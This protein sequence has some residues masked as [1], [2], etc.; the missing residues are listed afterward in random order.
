LSASPSDRAPT[1]PTAFTL[2][3]VLVVIAI[4]ALL[5]AIV[6][7]ALAAAR[8]SGD[9]VH[10][11]ASH[12]SIAQ[13]QHQWATDH[14]DAWPNAAHPTDP[15]S[16]L[17]RFDLG[18]TG[19]QLRAIDQVHTWMA[20]LVPQ[21][22]DESSGFE[23]WSCRSRLRQHG[24][25]ITQNP[26]GAAM[27]S[28]YQPAAMFTDPSLWTA[29]AADARANP[30]T[31]IRPVRLHEFAFASQKVSL[32]ELFAMHGNL[33]SAAHTPD[34][35]N[36]AFVDG[37]ARI[38]RPADAEKCLTYSGQPQ[39]MQHFRI[40]FGGRPLAFNSVVNGARGFDFR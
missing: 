29:D 37:H 36:A 25:Q 35:L 34:L 10:C 7:P 30:H 16:R 6:L 22:W 12:R 24:G 39:S 31:R 19:Y 5:L 26:A 32:S 17:Y 23:A 11:A 8:A 3:E 14:A 33:H 4:T 21:L 13:L 9:T 15:P 40:S 28:F 1:L 27:I 38:V 2:I 18:S 20:P